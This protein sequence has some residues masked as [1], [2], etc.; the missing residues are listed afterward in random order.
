[1]IVE[2]PYF[3]LY[4]LTQSISIDVA[5]LIGFSRPPA[6]R[7]YI[8]SWGISEVWEKTSTPFIFQT[9]L[10]ESPFKSIDKIII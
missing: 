4:T 1:M 3:D 7:I 5:L 2:T 6:R 10:D 8:G 9:R